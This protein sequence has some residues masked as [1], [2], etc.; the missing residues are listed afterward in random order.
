MELSGPDPDIHVDVD[1]MILDY[2]LC[3]TLESILSA[4]QVRSEE[5]GEHNSID[6]SIATIYAFKRLIPDPALIPEDIHTK[7]KILELADEIR[8]CASPAEILRDYVPLCRSRYPRRRWV[9]VAC[10]LIA[11]GAITAAK[12]PGI[13]LREGLNTHIAMTETSPN[14]ER[15]RNATTQITSYF[16]PPPDTPLDAHIRRISTNLTPARLRQELFNTLLDI[17][18]TQDPP[19]LVQLERGKLAGL[20]RA[21]TQQLKERAGIR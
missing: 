17:M 12:E 21:E 13:T 3:M 11:Q 6:S 18:K 15:M 20:S 9:G 19:I 4:G 2:L 8:R 14:E 1:L 16:E 5:K 7:L 10:Q